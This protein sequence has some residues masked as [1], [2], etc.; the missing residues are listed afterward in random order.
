MPTFLILYYSRTGNT[1][2]M[3]NSIAEGA[4]SVQGVE[5]EVKYNETSENLEKYDAIVIGT[6]TYH[7]D[8]TID[9]KNL[10]EEAAMKKV[11][12][13][14]KVGA[15]FGSFGWSGEAPQLVYEIMRNKFELNIEEQPLRIKY[16][17]DGAGL[18]RCKDLGRR[19]AKRL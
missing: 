8:M 6:P 5:V 18:E 15:V 19:I 4:K 11:N 9:I 3:A 17:P 10:L 2:R 7:H 13:K 1:E 12:L 16:T 14:G